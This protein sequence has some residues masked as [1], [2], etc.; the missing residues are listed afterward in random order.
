MDEIIIVS[1][2]FRESIAFASDFSSGQQPRSHQLLLARFD[3]SFA[4]NL[5]RPRYT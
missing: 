1:S 4:S 5:P 2:L 3:R